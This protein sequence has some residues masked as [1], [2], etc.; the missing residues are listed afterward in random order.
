[1]QRHVARYGKWLAVLCLLGLWACQAPPKPE[2]VQPVSIPDGEIDPAI[3][4]KAYPEQY[5]TWK[6][7]EKPVDTR[8]S[9]YKTGMDGGL[10]T[11]DKLSQFPYMALLFNGWGFGIE[12]NEP[13]GHAYMVRD[14]LE[15]DSSRLK[16]G[17]VC[18]SCKSPYAVQLE[19]EMGKDYY[20]KPFG[21]VIAKIPEA[22]REL[23]VACIDCHNNKDLGLQVSRG[24]TLTKALKDIGAPEETLTRQQMR[25]VVC[26][27]C[28][29]T[30]NIP[31]D[32]NKQ[33]VGL[34]F[35]W[36]GSTWG[37]ISVEN[38]IKQI[39]NDPSVVE[40]KQTVTGFGM[41]FMR[42]PEFEYFTMGSTHFKAGASCADCHMPYTTQGVK[43][44]SDHRVMSPVQGDMKACRQCHAES[45]DWLRERVFAIQDRT[46]SL[47]LRAGYA[48]ATVAKLFELT[49][50]RQAEGV[51]M[52][53]EMYDKAK[54]L[55]MEG[56][57]RQLFMGAE[58][59]VGFHNPAEG[60]RILG[61][62]VA[63]STKAEGLLRQMLAQA[64]VDV[65]MSI[66]LELA[67]YLD[68]RGE[69]QLM[70]NPAL[71]FK[72]PFGLQD[73]FF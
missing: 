19:K 47:M 68:N 31:K 7:T 43:K 63:F 29:V 69:R 12:Y 65:P 1:M 4:G 13:R 38:I 15:I 57:L 42:H 6:L 5:E 49:H 28:H 34:Y 71:E 16:A 41:P 60:M 32:E 72:D 22:T 59:S 23:G 35:P 37:N 24:F 50:A 17:G 20:A 66:D 70:F 26:A 33:S 18:L 10:V 9:K 27:Q 48:S 67:K 8:R 73:K 62:S 44:F 53:Q 21:E 55:Y 40:W 11:V 46:V 45:T 39:R 30:Y 3:W 14:Q 25:S 2:M 64:G 54:D 56:F 58:N 51:Q 52:N 36:Q 61:D